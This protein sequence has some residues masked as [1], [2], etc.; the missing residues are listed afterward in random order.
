MAN[1]LQIYYY[2]YIWKHVISFSSALSPV[3]LKFI[4]QDGIYLFRLFQVDMYKKGLKLFSEINLKK[5]IFKY[6]DNGIVFDL[7]PYIFNRDRCKTKIVFIMLK[8]DFNFGFLKGYYDQYGII[9]NIKYLDSIDSVELNPHEYQITAFTLALKHYELVNKN[10]E[11]NFSKYKYQSK[12][13][14]DQVVW[15]PNP[16]TEML[17]SYIILYLN[18]RKYAYVGPYWEDINKNFIYWKKYI[19]K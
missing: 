15:V 11:F 18:Q 14:C 10:I 8:E 17:G 12:N 4:S 16:N 13:T 9:K 2:T 5:D 6:Q 1:I 3:T 19:K 7:S